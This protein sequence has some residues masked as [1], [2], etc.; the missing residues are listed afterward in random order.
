M[1]WGFLVKFIILYRW[2]SSIKGAEQVTSMIARLLADALETHGYD[3]W[4]DKKDLSITST[5][6]K[7]S[8]STAMDKTKVAVI[9]IGVGDLA[10]CSANDDFFR[11]EID[12]TRALETCGKP[13]VVVVVHGTHELEDLICGIE[14]DERLR[15]RTF[16]SLGRW[17]TDF[18]DYLRNHYVMFFDINRLD[19]TA[20]QIIQML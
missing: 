8:L 11:W 12:R 15:K 3:P 6:L 16:R 7:D 2:Q 20:A 17:C 5:E 13:K 14:I 10:R 19:D 1:L 4:M 9:C 18:L